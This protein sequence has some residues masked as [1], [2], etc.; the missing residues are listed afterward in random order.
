MRKISIIAAAGA[1]A[2]GVALALSAPT[3]AQD[4]GK[5]AELK[6]QGFA[7]VA[8]ANEPPFTAVAADGKVSGAA[9]DVARE[10]VRMLVLHSLVGDATLGRGLKED[11]HVLLDGLVSYWALRDDAGAREQ[12]WLRAAALDEPLPEDY[13]TAWARTS[14]RLGE[15]QALA[16]SFSV[17]DTL[18]ERAGRDAT[19]QAMKEIFREPTD[20]ARVL[21][22][23]LSL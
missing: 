22:E 14:E 17:F 3:T 18:V 16:L 10:N 4:S 15:C 1:A 5:L 11:R 19:L 2:V 9:P 13:L 8:I 12:W 7:R 21:F 6:E 23:R 20:D